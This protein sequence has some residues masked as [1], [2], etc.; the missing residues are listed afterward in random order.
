ME[1]YDS[2][3]SLQELTKEI[4][5]NLIHDKIFSHTDIF[6]FSILNIKFKYLNIFRVC[7]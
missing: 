2:I 7:D 4:Y 1:F 5:V 3:D 6:F